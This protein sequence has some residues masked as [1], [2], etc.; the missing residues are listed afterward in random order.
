MIFSKRGLQNLLT[1]NTMN[2]SESK[3]EK[4]IILAFID[5]LQFVE[6]VATPKRPDGTY[7]Y[8]REALELKAI[9]VLRNI[10]NQ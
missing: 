4:E 3:N 1:K 8:C 9:E 6:L 10:R 2:M 5:L 7:N